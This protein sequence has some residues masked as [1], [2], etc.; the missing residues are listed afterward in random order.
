VAFADVLRGNADSLQNF[1]A[2]AND[3]L[4]GF[5][6]AVDEAAS[7]VPLIGK[8]FKEAGVDVFDSMSKAGLSIYDMSKAMDEGGAAADSFNVQLAAAKEAG[9]ITGEQYNAVSEALSKYSD[10]AMQAAKAAGLFNVS[11]DEA[12]AILQDTIAQ[13]DPMAQMAGSW[14]R[15]MAD[16]ADNGAI[17]SSADAVNEL[18]DALGK[19]RWPPPSP[20]PTSPCARASTPPGRSPR[21]SARSTRPASSTSARWPRTPSA[22]STT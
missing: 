1:I 17:N 8:Y 6:V 12:N 13:A 10:S 22:P 7:H 5:G 15:L 21:R 11:Q 14:A 19:P 4:G 9:L 20:T 2:N 18:A 16:M 3:P